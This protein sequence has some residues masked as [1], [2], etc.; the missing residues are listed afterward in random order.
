MTKYRILSSTDNKNIGVEF[1]DEFPCE[2]SDSSFYPDGE[3]DLGE[4]KFRFYNSN[5]S[6]DVAV[7]E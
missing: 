7:I 6:V 1:I 4:G 5:Y 2:L 3:I